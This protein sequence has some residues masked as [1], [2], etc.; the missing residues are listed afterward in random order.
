ME[1]SAL[2]GHSPK[3]DKREIVGM[4]KSGKHNSSGTTY[5]SILGDCFLLTK[6]KADKKYMI[7]TDKEMYDYFLYRCKEILDEIILVHLDAD[8]HKHLLLLKNP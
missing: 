4:V 8:K 2:H 6:V 1:M 5:H 3:Y 7:L